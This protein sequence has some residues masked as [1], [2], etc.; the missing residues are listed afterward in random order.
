MA[1]YQGMNI[2]VAEINNNC[3]RYMIVV[4]VLQVYQL[5]GKHKKRS[6]AV[7]YLVLEA[8]SFL[9]DLYGKSERALLL[10]A[11][12]LS[13]FGFAMCMYTCIMGRSRG[14]TSVQ[15]QRLLRI[16]C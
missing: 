14:S 7:F 16:K 12:L 5:L 15:S 2:N 9:L 6:L 3:L 10:A 11:F 4:F 1:E 13:A 8:A